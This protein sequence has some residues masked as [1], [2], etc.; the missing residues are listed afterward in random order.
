M[1]SQDLWIAVVISN[2]IALLLILICYKWPKTGKV[3][4]S[5]IFLLAGIF[6]MYS[7]IADPEV[8]VNTYG[9]LAIGLYQKI[10]YGVFSSYTSL[11]VILIA[12][13][14]LLV[15]IFLLLKR[16][17]FKL[18]ILG[19]IIFLI[20]ISPLGIGSAFPFPLL[21][22]ISLVLLYLRYKKA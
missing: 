21:M 6:N 12:V 5:I 18:G 4:S 8:Y 3:V 1:D 22:S 16:T 7:G 17:L 9:P 13:G 2:V 10:I 14:Q 11:F 20:S 19:G 15:G